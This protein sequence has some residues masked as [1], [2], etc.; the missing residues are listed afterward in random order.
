MRN[1]R[2]LELQNLDQFSKAFHPTDMWLQCLQTHLYANINFSHFFLA[3]F[4]RS[5]ETQ[6]L[7]LNFFVR[8]ALGFLY[9]VLDQNE[10]NVSRWRYVQN[11]VMLEVRRINWPVPKIPA[12]VV[13]NRLEKNNPFNNYSFLEKPKQ[14]KRNI[15]KLL[16]RSFLR[17]SPEMIYSPKGR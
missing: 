11:W 12:R 10:C 13:S 2:L 5:P 4:L 1:H 17:P 15:A 8:W 6:L 3:Q 7:V 14:P 9:Q 16:K